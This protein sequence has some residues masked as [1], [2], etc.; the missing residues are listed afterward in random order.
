VSSSDDGGAPVEPSRLFESGADRSGYV[1]RM[2]GDIAA[3]YDL[4]NTVMTAGRHHAWRR[5]AAHAVVRPG[6]RVVDAGCGTGDL[7]FACIEAGADAV[8]GVDFAEP[9]LGRARAKAARRDGVPGWGERASDRASFALGD[10]TNLPLPDRSVDVWCSAFVVRN[11]PDLDA[12]LREALRVLK[13]GGRL[14]I[15]EIPRMAPSALR[16]FARFHFN[17]VVPLMG[18]A[19]SGHDSAYS[20]LPVSVDQFL[21]T[22][23][24]AARLRDVGFRVLEVRTLMFGT[25]ALH[26]A[27]RPRPLPG[28]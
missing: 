5:M 16:P 18:R 3:R 26:V 21:S 14:G 13:P 10:A 12:A 6:D 19:V 22:E 20:Y 9:M 24:L 23:E 8:L 15:L 2:F 27:E 17:R 7:A 25:V 1:R 11:I 28:T 4:M